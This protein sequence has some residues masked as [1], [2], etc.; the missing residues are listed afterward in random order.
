MKKHHKR[1]YICSAL[2]LAICLPPAALAQ[3]HSGSPQPSIAHMP[4]VTK[5]TLEPLPTDHIFTA[6]PAP[7]TSEPELSASTGKLSLRPTTGW[8][9]KS[10]NIRK[11]SLPFYWGQ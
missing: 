1:P 11:T 10:Q 7:E 8:G 6:P 5:P 2:L 9:R 4:D 3:E